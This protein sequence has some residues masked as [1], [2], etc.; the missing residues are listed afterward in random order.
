MEIFAISWSWITS[1]IFE[2]L[3]KNTVQDGIHV[4]VMTTKFTAA[5]N[6]NCYFFLPLKIF[7]PFFPTFISS[8]GEKMGLVVIDP[9]E[10]GKYLQ[11]TLFGIKKEKKFHWLFIWK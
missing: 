7:W 3:K 5:K 6:C 1:Q 8:D 4:N 9:K 10:G 11:P 2:S